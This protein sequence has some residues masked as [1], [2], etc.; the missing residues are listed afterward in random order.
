MLNVLV[1]MLWVGRIQLEV[2]ISNIHDCCFAQT[3]APGNNLHVM[4]V[5]LENTLQY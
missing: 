5:S 1:K 3:K 2:D 4:I